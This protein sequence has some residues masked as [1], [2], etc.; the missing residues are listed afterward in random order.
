MI[1]IKSMDL[2][3][4]TAYV[5][6]LGQPAFRAGQVFQWLHRGVRSFEEMSNLPKAPAGAARGGV[7]PGSAGGGAQAGLRPWTER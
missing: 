4:L 3:E 6:S 7:P 5:Q 1:D 2:A